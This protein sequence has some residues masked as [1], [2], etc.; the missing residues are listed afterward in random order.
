M[1]GASDG[2]LGRLFSRKAISKQDTPWLGSERGIFT[3]SHRWYC[4]LSCFVLEAFSR[5]TALDSGFTESG[6]V[7]GGDS[8][9]L[10]ECWRGKRAVMFEIVERRRV[11]PV[12]T[13]VYVVQ[14]LNPSCYKCKPSGGSMWKDLKDVQDQGN[15]RSSGADRTQNGSG[16]EVAGLRATYDTVG[17]I[18][19]KCV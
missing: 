18:P 14:Q 16:L 3:P 2:A 7:L 9:G 19:I 4:C 11:K 8:Y 15:A 1:R 12:S 10:V 6:F 5:N 17:I 13:A